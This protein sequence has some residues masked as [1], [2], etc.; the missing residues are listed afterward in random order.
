[1]R[2]RAVMFDL[3]GTLL[4]TLKDIADSVNESLR[5]MGL[6]QHDVESYRYLIGSGREALVLGALPE[7]RRDAATVGELTALVEQEYSRRWVNNTKPYPGIPELLDSL[8]AKGVSIAILSNKPQHNTDLS[9]SRLLS[10]WRFEAVVGSTPSL[11]KKPDPAGALQIAHKLNIPTR[12]FIYVGDSGID[13]KTAT[14]A[15][16]YPVGVLWGFRSSDELLDSGAK[17]LMKQAADLLPLL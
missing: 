16:M 12:E 7:P 3:D 2:Y 15:G 4:D 6:P 17:E 1:M 8:T 11:P 14:A 9:V 5:R 13:M 10:R